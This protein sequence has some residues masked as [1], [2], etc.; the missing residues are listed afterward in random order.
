MGMGKGSK[1]PGPRVPLYYG[2]FLNAL[3]EEYDIVFEE[4]TTFL[5]HTRMKHS[6]KRE[7]RCD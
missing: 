7:L 4:T 2:N 3:T 1:L 5:E 6:E